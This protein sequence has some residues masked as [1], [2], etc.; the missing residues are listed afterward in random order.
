M[1]KCGVKQRLGLFLWLMISVACPAAE[2]V[3]W[4]VPLTHFVWAGLKSQGVVRLESAP[5]PSPFFKKGD[6]LW[7]LRGIPAVDRSLED[8]P[9]K[10]QPLR[11]DTDPPMEWV[12]WNASTERLVT[13]ADWNAIFQLHQQFRLDQMP[14][15]IRLTA[16]VFEVPP[17]GAAPSEKST[18]S[19]TLAWVTRSGFKFK[20][21]KEADSTGIKAEGELSCS[22]AFI[23]LNLYGRCSVRDH[24]RLEFNCDLVLRSGVPYW[25]ARDFNGTAGL[26]CRVSGRIEL[27]DGTPLEE[28]VLIQK[29]QSSEPLIRDL[30]EPVKHRIGEKNRLIICSLDPTKLA[31]CLDPGAGSAKEVDPFA[32]NPPEM[33]WKFLKLQ[34]TKVPDNLKAW[35]PQPV[36]DLRNQIRAMGIT[37]KDS[38]YAGY[39][40]YSQRIFLFTDNESE[41][42][43]FEVLF[44]PI[45]EWLPKQIVFSLNGNGE[46]R[47]ITRSGTI[48]K[49]ARIASNEVIRSIQIEPTIDETG[50]LIDVRLEYLDQPDSIHH[51]SINA[52]HILR[53]GKA[54]EIMRRA[55]NDA[56]PLSVKAEIVEVPR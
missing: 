22:D 45:C 46:S 34:E 6:E 44:T 13:K 56:E 39:S 3:A 23:N 9:L 16:E 55:G 43:K 32:E 5:E 48:G 7:N 42:D 2:I 1:R 18:P 31:Y 37:V 38:D 27:I 25:V 49:L 4:K 54:T 15:Q 53:S 17:N 14:K 47:L 30:S 41:L 51:E 21:S 35:F 50:D 19:A 33:I 20:A 36:F 28:A 26:D 24:P 10:P 12:I 11:V 40:P 29:L 8:L 52:S